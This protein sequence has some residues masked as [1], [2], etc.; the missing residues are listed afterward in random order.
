MTIW[1]RPNWVIVGA[2]SG[3]RADCR[4]MNEDWVRRIRDECVAADVPFFLKQMVVDGKLNH[5]PL[6]DG[7]RWTQWPA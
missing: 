3:P 1:F 6:L 2:E 4:P 5:E 7:E